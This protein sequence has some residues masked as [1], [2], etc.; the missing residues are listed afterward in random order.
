MDLKLKNLFEWI[1]KN[2]G[3]VHPNVTYNGKH[4]LII[5]ENLEIEGVHLFSFPKKLCIDSGTYKNYNTPIYKQ[6]SIDEQKC[7]NQPFFKLILNLISE[8]LKGNK[9]FYKPFLSSFPPMEELVKTS[10]LFYYNE[11]KEDWKKVLPT[12]ITKLDNLNAFY[13]NL[14]LI[15]VKLRI[16]KIN[17]RLFPGYNTEDEILKTIVLWAFLIVNNYAMEN[18]YLLP[19]FNLMHYSHGTKNKIVRDNNRINFSFSDVDTQLLIANNGILDNETLFAL[20]GYINKDTVQKYLEIK[21]SNKYTL[22]DEENPQVKVKVEETFQ[23][24]FKRNIQK[25]YISNDNPSPSLVQYLRIVSLINSDLN[26]I[27][28]DD[29]Y[30]T[31]FI[32]MDNE[33]NVYKKLLKIVKIKYSHIKDGIDEENETDLQDIKILKLLLKEQK[34]ILKNMYYSIHK[35]WLN[36]MESD[37][38]EELFKQTFKLE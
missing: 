10:P 32:S 27:Q 16:F 11:R 7:F 1:R 34:D 38:D 21:I 4:K 28:G 29:Q 13:I 37:Y 26:I 2:D 8:K 5:S 24:L 6:F 33:S 9:S 23:N 19:L 31:K 25:Y 17:I 35:K 30:F 3:F 15:I 12:L 18:E 36:I 20:Y 22:E 14:Y